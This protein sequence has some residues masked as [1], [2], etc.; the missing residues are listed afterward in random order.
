MLSVAVLAGGKAPRAPETAMALDYLAR[1]REAGARLG[2]SGFAL[3]EVD[4]RRAAA[5]GS[6]GALDGLTVA[7]DEGGQAV[8]STD[9]AQ[10][11]AR[12]RDGGAA[13]VT[14][15]IGGADGLPKDLKGAASQTWSFGRATWP[16][17]VVRILLAEQLYRAMAILSGHP[18]HRG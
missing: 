5:W 9:I 18:Y 17:L 14:F 8:S 16:H 10:S 11:L 7:L 15:L 1:A 4:D 12:A 2:F 13:R 3:T 6:A